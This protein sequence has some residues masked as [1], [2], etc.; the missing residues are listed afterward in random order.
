MTSIISHRGN[1]FGHLENSLVALQKALASPHCDGIEC[2]VRITKDKH[3]VLFHDDYLERISTGK[4]RVKDHTLT[5][6][7]RARLV[8]GS[9]I[10][11]LQEALLLFK[12]FKKKR[13]FIE[14]KDTG[15]E[16]HFASLLTQHDCTHCSIVSWNAQALARIHDTHP[17]IKTFLLYIPLPRLLWFLRLK[18]ALANGAEHT[19][20]LVNRSQRTQHNQPIIRAHST[21]PQ[22]RG[23]TGYSI[24]ASCTSARLLEQC[25]ARK[26]ELV[27]FDVNTLS[28]VLGLDG[29]ITDRPLLF[30]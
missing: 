29:I 6:L 18:R 2:D 13:I 9:E 26:K 16:E 25:H 8:D 15:Y 1:G 19:L 14:I 5:Q 24:P 20:L 21:P 23:L 27:A 7:K 10:T 30:R 12:M 3:F 4:G 22:V 11:T 28:K 17:S